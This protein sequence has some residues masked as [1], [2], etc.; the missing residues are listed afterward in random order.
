[1]SVDSSSQPVEPSKLALGEEGNQTVGDD[2]FKHT[3]VD[4]PD[5]EKHEAESLVSV[6]TKP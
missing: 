1:V 5:Q 6:P 2:I 3:F 4:V